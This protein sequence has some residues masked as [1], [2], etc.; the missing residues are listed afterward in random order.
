MVYHTQSVA[1]TECVTRS[2]LVDNEIFCVLFN[3]LDMPVLLITSKTREHSK[4]YH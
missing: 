1:A 3:K 4:R 2:W